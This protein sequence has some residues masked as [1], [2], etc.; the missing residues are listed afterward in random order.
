MPKI[1]QN[2]GYSSLEIGI[3][4]AMAPL[5]RFIVPFTFLK[6]VRL[7]KNIF[8]LALICLLLSAAS[9]YI[10]IHSFW[11]FLCSNLILGASFGLILP[12]IETYA[13][14]YLK[15]ERYGKSRLFG[16]IGFMLIGIVLA[17]NLNNYSVGIHY[18]F[19][20]V[21]ATCLFGF[22][23][24]CK[25]KDFQ[26]ESPTQERFELKKVTFIW[27]SL[28]LMQVS[29]GA[30]YNFFTIYET[31]HGV[32]LETISYLWAFGV[33]CE[34]VFFYFQAPLLKYNL[35]SIIKAATFFAACRWFL[36][37]L[38]PDSLFITFFSQSFHAIAFALH[39]T[40]AISLLYGIYKNK[41]LAAQFYYGF[42]FGLGGFLGAILAGFFYGKYLYLYASIVAFF[43][44]LALFGQKSTVLKQNS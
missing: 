44:F 38:F 23:V 30:F 9:F 3:V 1:L 17:R 18:F 4:F 13:M 27:I 43:A 41:K 6:H 25:N 8:Y 12:Y 7:T 2:I 32:S 28:F 10:F 36:L 35:L 39:H 37:F 31:A 29:F 21:F 33:I 16:S 22:L 15:K 5:M 20:A 14:G 19:A 40:A 42:S 26:K 24:T 34:I 11:F